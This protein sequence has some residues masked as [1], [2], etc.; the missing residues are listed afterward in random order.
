MLTPP[1]VH[2]TWPWSTVLTQDQFS[3]VRRLIRF[4]QTYKMRRDHGRSLSLLEPVSSVSVDLSV[5]KL[6]Y[7]FKFSSTLAS[8]LKI[9][10]SFFLCLKNIISNLSLSLLKVHKSWSKVDIQCAVVACC[11]LATSRYTGIG[12][13]VS[14]HEWVLYVRNKP[15]L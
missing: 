15:T 8:N 1:V 11:R 9:W 14:M 13:M 6:G 4:V 3:N 10:D 12:S 5:S 2:S 7:D